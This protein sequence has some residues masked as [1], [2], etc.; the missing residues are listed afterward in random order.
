[1]SYVQPNSTIEFFSDLNLSQDYNDSL[2]FET[3][4]LRDIYFTNIQ[5]LAVADRCYYARDNRGFVRVELPIGTMMHAQYM[6][7]KNTSYENNW[8]YAFVKDVVYINDHTVE[9]Q[10]ELDI[11]MSYMGEFTLKACYIERQHVE[12]DSI[13]ANLVDEN[14]NCGEYVNLNASDETQDAF[15]SKTGWF[16]SF[17]SG[18]TH[19][20]NNNKAWSYLAFVS[21]PLLV[22][23]PVR[24]GLGI[25]NGLDIGIYANTPAG[26]SDMNQ[27]LHLQDIFGNVISICL[28]PEK[29]I[30]KIPNY[31]VPPY[32]GAVN[33][34]TVNRDEV[35]YVLT[36]SITKSFEYLGDLPPSVTGHNGYL[37]VNN[38]LYTYPYNFLVV[39]NSEGQE[40]IYKYEL[41][42]SSS[43]NF[44]LSA[45]LTQKPEIVCFPDNYRGV[46]KNTAESIIMSHFPMAGWSSDLFM[47]Y[48]A[49]ALSTAPLA[50]ID[51]SLTALG[52]SSAI[53]STIVGTKT[54]R[55]IE[56]A[57]KQADLALN[58]AVSSALNEG[59]QH[60]EKP[61]EVVGQV[62]VDALTIMNNKDFYFF[63]RTV[64]PE[65]AEMIDNYFT[66]FGYAI[67]KVAVPNMNA[68]TRFT[69]VKT[70]GC[71]LNCACPA[72]DADFIEQL[73]NR[74]IR[75][76]KN[77]LDIGN[78]DDPNPPNPTE[79]E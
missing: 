36:K 13:G 78:Y 60:L 23:S 50:M 16:S 35:P 27:A 79:G 43:C 42:S 73:F 19:T 24:E 25:Y 59:I 11:L 22:A 72:S 26:R 18:A 3:P 56:T 66:M 58:S 68:R 57:T 4:A 62:A 75:F 21:Q 63:R 55:K 20:W 39:N 51:P 49:Q 15:D 30:P 76:W 71:K 65:Y 7:F 69:Y 74:G 8:W 34:A 53:E 38:K 64:R 10:F 46:S 12:D 2:Y 41:F 9:V 44:E 48:A 45:S 61:Q 17:D 31:N 28:L 54:P 47:A 52:G 29:F 77:H 33:Y 32:L 1:M 5:K 40:M 6:R 67:K 70:I 37:P 14:F